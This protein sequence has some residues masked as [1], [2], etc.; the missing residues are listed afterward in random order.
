MSDN[1][2]SPILLAQ[3]TA[4]ETK[5]WQALVTGDTLADSQLLTVDFLGVYPSGFATKAEHCGQLNEG[6][7]MRSF[8][9]SQAQLKI[10]SPEAVL[11]SYCA[12]YQR[13]NCA[14]EE[15]MYITSLW[16]RSAKG[17]LN[18]FSQDTPAA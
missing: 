8:S 17:W 6:P 13:A 2:P 7:V 15:G 11:L 12:R 3:I 16:Q 18:S 10:I 1:P 4:L 5:V 14:Q 9:L